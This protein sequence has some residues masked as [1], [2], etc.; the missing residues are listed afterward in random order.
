MK[1]LK[2]KISTEKDKRTFKQSHKADQN[3][4]TQSKKDLDFLV[5]ES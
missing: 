4:L 3:T 1:N 2:F 5:S